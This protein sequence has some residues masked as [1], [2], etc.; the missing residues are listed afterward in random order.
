MMLC[1]GCDE[2]GTR[3][4]Y[5]QLPA[6]FRSDHGKREDRRKDWVV[7]VARLCPFPP[8][9]CSLGSCG[10]V[11]SVA[12]DRNGPYSYCVLCVDVNGPG[13]C[14]V[15]RLPPVEGGRGRSTAGVQ[16]RPTWHGHSV[17]IRTTLTN[18][19]L[20][21]KADSL[22][23]THIIDIHLGTRA[24]TSTTNKHLTHFLEGSFSSHHHP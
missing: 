14:G 10:I 19:R 4:V 17:M 3:V 2:G 23:L 5:S 13:G 21:V 20:Q 12:V 1:F 18:G 11:C 16:L 24:I 7:C 9:G 22:T 15:S 8:L 6:V